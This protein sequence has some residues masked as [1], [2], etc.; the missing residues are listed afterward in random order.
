MMKGPTKWSRQKPAKL[1][2]I[3][4][5]HVSID[6]S[7]DLDLLICVQELQQEKLLFTD[8]LSHIV[9]S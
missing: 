6:Q 7:D 2:L 8:I 1:T 4:L 9:K 5:Q 3:C